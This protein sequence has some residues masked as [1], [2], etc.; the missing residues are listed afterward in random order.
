MMPW[1]NHKHKATLLSTTLRGLAPTLSDILTA[2]T[3]RVAIPM[4]SVA[5]SYLK[6]IEPVATTIAAVPDSHFRNSSLLAEIHPPPW[7]A[8]PVG[9]GARVPSVLGVCVAIDS[10]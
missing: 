8:I 9:V 4:P 2:P 6:A 10:A 5:N 7:V 3:A 1:A